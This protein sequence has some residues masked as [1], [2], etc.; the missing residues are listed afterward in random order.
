MKRCRLIVLA[1]LA[2]VLL[3]CQPAA[4]S[5]PEARAP[6][7]T[8]APVSGRAA[9]PTAEPI[10]TA[11]P[12]ATIEAAADEWQTFTSDEGGFSL[13]L[14]DQPKEQRQ[15]INTAAGS[16]DAIMYFDSFTLLEK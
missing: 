2:A 7:A 10:D 12:I 4:T 1:M 13:L 3:A 11:E 9:I 15:P 16:I 6:I 5:T 14:P 8:R